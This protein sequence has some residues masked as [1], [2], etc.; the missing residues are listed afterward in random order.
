MIV[1]SRSFVVQENTYLTEKRKNLYSFC[2]SVCQLGILEASR[3]SLLLFS[4][5]V[6]EVAFKR[7][8]PMVGGNPSCHLHRNMT[9][10]VTAPLSLS[11]AKATD[12]GVINKYFDMLEATFAAS[13]RPKGVPTIYTLFRAQIEKEQQPPKTAV[14]HE[15]SKGTRSDPCFNLAHPEMKRFTAYLQSYDGERKQEQEARSI[16]ADV[17][18]L[19][20]Y[21]SPDRINWLVVTDPIKVREYLDNLKQRSG[22]GTDG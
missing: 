12:V 4:V 1:C 6:I 17:S 19:L 16:T 14:L 5:C 13:Q 11:R 3:W 9:L 21:A 22:V 18:K 8:C 15:P 10:R 2:W 7:L 20:K